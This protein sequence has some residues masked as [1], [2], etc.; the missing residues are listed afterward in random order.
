MNGMEDSEMLADSTIIVR[1]C[2]SLAGWNVWRLGSLVL[3]KGSPPPRAK[4][5]CALSVRVL[6]RIGLIRRGAGSGSL[7]TLRTVVPDT[8]R[9]K[10]ISCVAYMPILWCTCVAA[11]PT[12]CWAYDSNS[13]ITELSSRMCVLAWSLIGML[14]YSALAYQSLPCGL[15]T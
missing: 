11:E 9:V 6:S 3:C 8:T 12:R 13:K 15:E 4:G 1:C 14:Q 5:M 7:R 10:D 2:K